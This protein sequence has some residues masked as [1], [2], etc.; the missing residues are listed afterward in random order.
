MQSLINIVDDKMLLTILKKPTGSL[1]SIIIIVAS[2]L[3]MWHGN[4]KSAFDLFLPVIRNMFYQCIT[5]IIN[6]V[7][8][9]LFW[10]HCLY[11]MFILCAQIK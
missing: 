3:C 2:S 11:S 6:S 9:F 10:C 1:L 7:M 5:I 8:F 4:T